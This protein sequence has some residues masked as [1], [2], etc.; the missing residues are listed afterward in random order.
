MTF[1]ELKQEIE[2]VTNNTKVEY[3]EDY[4]R[5]FIVYKLGRMR[6][7]LIEISES[8]RRCILIDD[9]NGIL[10]DEYFE[11]IA[12]KAISY[13]ATPIEERKEIGIPEF[14]DK[15]LSNMSG[16]SLIYYR[17]VANNLLMD[18]DRELDKREE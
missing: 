8:N 17:A 6:R 10:N 3:D 15:E 14:T 5:T 16:D 18:V 2:E 12:T 1:N 4:N 13:A 9:A 11:Y 7:T